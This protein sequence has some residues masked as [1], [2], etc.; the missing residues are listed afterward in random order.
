MACE[1]GQGKGL[2]KEGRWDTCFSVT[3]Q[4]E[5]VLAN[6]DTFALDGGAN[7]SVTPDVSLS[8]AIMECMGNCHTACPLETNCLLINGDMFTGHPHF[9]RLLI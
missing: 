3:I 4:Q 5:G 7:S 9:V 6:G 2:A 1:A 8:L